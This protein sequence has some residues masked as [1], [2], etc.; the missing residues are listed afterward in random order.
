M[1]VLGAIGPALLLAVV[2]WFAWQGFST[3]VRQS[4]EALTD[5]ALASNRFAAQYVARTAGDELVRRYEMVEEVARSK[6]FRGML[7]EMLAKPDVQDVADEAERP[8]AE[9]RRLGAAAQRVPRSARP[10][11]VA[12]GV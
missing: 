10:A 12:E 3:A 5:R 8:E 4:N 2:T 6:P 7:A 9:P 11:G 1:M